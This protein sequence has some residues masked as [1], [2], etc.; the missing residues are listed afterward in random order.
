MSS[1]DQLKQTFF[2]ECSEALQQIE[3]GL[4]DIRDDAGSEDTINAVFRSVHSIKGGAGIFGFED[5]VKFAHV[6][7]TVLDGMRSGNLVATPDIVDTLLAANDVLSDLVSMSRS[8]KAIPPDFGSESHAALEQIL[9]A[10]SGGEQAEDDSPAPADFDGLDF[11]P[12]RADGFDAVEDENTEREYKIVFRPKPDLLKKGNEPLYILRELRKL[13]TLNLVVETDRLPHLAD[14]EVDRPYLGWAGTLRTSAKREQIDEIFEFVADDCELEITAL[15]NEPDFGTSATAAEPAM[16]PSPELPAISQPSLPVAEVAPPLATPASQPAPLLGAAAE[17]RSAASKPAAAGATTTRVELEK[18]DRVVNMVG[19]LVI[20]QA[21]L[22]QVVHSLPEDVSSRLLQVLEEVVHHTRELKDSVMSM[23]AQQVNAVFQ[24]MPRLVRELAAK[25]GKKVRLELA[26]ENTEVDRSIIERLADPLTHIIRN[27]IDHGIEAPAVRIAAGKSEEGTIRL[28]AEHRGSR[29]VIEI[30][31]DG[32]GINSERVLQK[33]RERGLVSPD[34]TLS[35]DEIN[36]L[37]FLPGF[38]TA[39]KISDI[40]GR[41]V[42]MDVVRRNIQD[43]GGRISLKSDRGRGMTIQLALPLTLAV[44]E[45]MV[46]RVASE[47]YVMPM[48][49]I[50]E[51]LRPPASEI[52]NLIGTPGMLRLRGNLVPLVQLCELLDLCPPAAPSD[53]RV[54]IITDAGEGTSFGIVVD[55]LCG[56]QQVVVKSIEESYGSVPGIAGA[57]ILGNGRVAFILD[58]EKLSDLANSQH[59][60]VGISR[61]TNG[62]ARAAGFVNG[63]HRVVSPQMTEAAF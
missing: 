27:S 17:P 4:T 19:E 47:T 8:A 36:N 41:G 28:S 30:R 55:E 45:G 56:H 48:S 20:A 58:V 34:A 60:S 16:S 14:L 53:E 10:N 35:E 39:E 59:G 18:I 42:G 32:A 44:M 1:L 63:A 31:D 57:T 43:V 21:M 26:G 15:S 51:C 6:F 24:R 5:L 33:A 40:S 46:I 38:S 25:T 62:D 22:G 7:E 54:V 13:G 23:R 2:D 11:M 3:L 12:V 61:F 9:Q 29:I 49:A 37:I 50:V 52:H